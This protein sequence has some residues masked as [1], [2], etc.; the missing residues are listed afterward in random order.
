MEYSKNCFTQIG[1]R[2]NCVY[3]YDCRL[4]P[5]MLEIVPFIQRDDETKIK[6]FCDEIN[7]WLNGDMEND[8]SITNY[9][10]S[11][12]ARQIITIS[13]VNEVKYEGTNPIMIKNNKGERI[14]TESNIHTLKENIFDQYSNTPCTKEELLE[15]SKNNLLRAYNDFVGLHKNLKGET[16]EGAI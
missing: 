13:K 10:D 14:M 5:T 12:D 11:I 4:S 16:N 6:K 3:C 1:F 2:T 15:K 8:L 9:L 7:E